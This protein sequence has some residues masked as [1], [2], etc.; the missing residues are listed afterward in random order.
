[1]KKWTA[2]E[3]LELARSY[4]AAAVL[5]AAAELD[6]FDHLA[7]ESLAAS[8]LA[9]G[10]GCDARGLTILLDALTALQLLVKRKRR[11]SVPDDVAAC[12]TAS[13]PRSVLAMARHQANCM[14]RW[15]QLARV[16]KAGRPADRVASV[17]GEAGDRESFIGAMQNIS[18]S[19]ADAVIRGIRPLRFKH[20]LDVGGASGTWTAA[21]L[22]ASP[23]ATATLFDL[24]PVLPM[25]R[26]ELAAKGL[27]KRVRLTAG[28]FLKDPLPGG[29]DL[30][31]VSAIV[32]QNSRKQNRRLFRNVFRALV[33]GGRIVIR[34]VLMDSTRTRPVAGA[35]F[36]V[37]MLVATEGGGT[38]TAT[39]LC[40]DL[41]GAGFVRTAVVRRDAG[42]H[43]LLIAEK[44]AAPRRP[45]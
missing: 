26:R 8:A 4:Q 25:A 16:V 19:V 13:S 15:A 1:M 28:D 29:A 43:S 9:R 42:M 10:M 14:R 18:V 7:V 40:E 34:D 23:R 39:E 38:F 35:L 20:L 6:V 33:P 5:V 17:R 44:P 21:F 32:H 2:D 31:W 27:G 24:P 12:L 30:A 22:R 36:A 41:Q 11:Y 37:N 3:I 45:F